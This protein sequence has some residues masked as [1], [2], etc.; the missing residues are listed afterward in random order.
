[1]FEVGW[2]VCWQLGGIYTVLRTKALAMTRR[3][4]D[5]YALIGP[6]N[7]ATAHGEFEQRPAEGWLAD[8]LE[9]LRGDGINV[10]HGLWLVNGRPT[11]LL[12]D[13]RS[14]MHRL[15]EWKYFMHADHGI[16]IQDGDAEI[17]ETVAFGFACTEVLAALARH[18][19]GPVIGHFHEWMAGIAV[20]R[21]AHLQHT[22]SPKFN[23]NVVAT[24]FTTHATLLGRYLANDVEDLYESL[25]HIDAEAAASHYNIATRFRLERA[26]AHGANVFST[27]SEIT[28]SEARHLLGR[29]PDAILPN[30]LDIQRFE[31]PHEFQFLHNRA[32][33]DIHNFVMGHFFPAGSFDLDNT[34]Y[35]F[36]SG[37]Y[38]YRNKGMDLFL[39]SLWRLNDRLKRRRAEGHEVPTV[40]AFIVT[41][42]AVKNINVET[43]KNQALTDD[44]RSYCDKLTEE[45]GR[46]LFRA[47]AAGRM[48]HRGELITEDA[49]IRLKRAIN[50]RTISR[51]PSIVT[52]DLVDD[53]DDPVLQHLRHRNLLNHPDDPVKVVF[54][55]Q[56]MTSTS[57]L[58]G[59]DYEHFVR[60]CHL[61]VFPSSYEPWG[62]T[63]MECIAS[64][65]PAVT[66]D[67]SGFGSYCLATNHGETDDG[68]YVLR[69]S[70][71]AFDHSAIALAEFLE[72]FTRRDRRERI[73]L[74]NR[75]ESGSGRY[76]WES[77]VHN[78]HDAHEMVLKR[79][80]A[81]S[82]EIEAV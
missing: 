56:F 35:L 21:L 5:R 25:E 10:L 78:Y 55:P 47:A 31:A 62:Y 39:E 6:Y 72:H 4:G 18:C 50:A 11:T 46:V 80:L 66:T 68:V 61:G 69:R 19:P 45:I 36:T 26:A 16:P 37:R 1:M 15:G 71:T 12:I 7:P 63:P 73:E 65:L 64:G 13:H 74:R 34:L 32:K 67:L 44:L 54:H 23:G 82:V 2:E 3:W 17:D 57:P 14:V 43:L 40:I 24:V 49:E 76:S 38:E 81:G 30:G 60:G 9:E 52:H 75:V 41:K 27:V 51:H 8:A 33:E 58:L 70:K 42:A 77:V 29:S 79:A 48:V 22:D 28:G 59:M 20:P 53:A